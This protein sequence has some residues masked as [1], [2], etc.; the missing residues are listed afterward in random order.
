M[1]NGTVAA[2]LCTD[3]RGRAAHGR[4]CLFL[5]ADPMKVR[6]LAVLAL[7]T[8]MWA[9]PSQAQ[10]TKPSQKEKGFTGRIESMTTD[11]NG[12]VRLN[13]L[14]DHR[15]VTVVVT[16]QTSVMLKKNAGS[17]SDIRP[18]ERVQVIPGASAADPA[19]EVHIL[20]LPRRGRRA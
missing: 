18:G 20:R 8:F 15:A 14:S 5:E 9:A 19:S 11:K 2:R 10:A 6:Y 12:D 17:L 13:I 1:R 16:S 4:A 7:V 3:G